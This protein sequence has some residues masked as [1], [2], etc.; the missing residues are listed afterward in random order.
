MIND[1]LRLSKPGIVRGN[2]IVAAACY[3]FAMDAFDLVEFGA[4]AVGLGLVIA[5]ACALNNYYDRDIDARMERTKHRPVPSGRIGA[6]GALLFGAVTALAGFA[7]LS[8]DGWLAV[9]GALAGFLLYVFAYTPM[10]H[11]SAQALYV[12]ALAG[13]TPTLVGYAA[14]AHALDAAAWG[15]FAFL[16]VWQLPHFGAIAIYRYDEYAAAG[17]PLLVTHPPSESRKRAARKA[18]YASLVVLLVFCG[19]LMLHRW[20]R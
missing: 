3:V 5:G 13:A 16:F 15:L 4:L 2:V 8:Y 19:A 11:W 18:F 20:T 6:T 17:V 12:G 14:A 9:A 7:F 1:Y 10:K